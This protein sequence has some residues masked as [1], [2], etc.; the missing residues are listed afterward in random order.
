[1]FLP[2][3]AHRL[4][5]LAPSAMISIQARKFRSNIS[6]SSS[7]NTL[8]NVSWDG[9][10]FANSRKVFNHSSFGFSI[11]VSIATHPICGEYA[12]RYPFRTMRLY[13]PHNIPNIA[14]VITST[15]L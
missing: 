4:L 3:I 13:A 12:E 1:M 6:G 15:S 9:T 14:M 2:S 11:R 8:P 7:L 5:V 10:L